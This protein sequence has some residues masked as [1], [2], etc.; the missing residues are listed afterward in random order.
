MPVQFCL[1]WGSAISTL[2]T[3]VSA[4]VLGGMLWVKVRDVP[5]RHCTTKRQGK[6]LTYIETDFCTRSKSQLYTREKFLRSVGG[7]VSWSSSRK[8]ALAPTD[9]YRFSAPLILSK[10]HFPP[11]LQENTKRS[12]M[13]Y[14]LLLKA[15]GNHHFMHTW[16]HHICESAVDTNLAF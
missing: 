8:C 15:V 7:S 1:I 11:C 5:T 6:T 16:E 13:R 3:K 9:P 12:S 4:D 14:L 10:F 2:L